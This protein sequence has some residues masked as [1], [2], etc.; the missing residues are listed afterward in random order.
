MHSPTLPFTVP[1]PA[2]L[3]FAFSLTALAVH[4]QT[5]SDRRK[6]RGLRYPLP[7]LLT[8]AV[9]AFPAGPGT[10]HG[11]Q[12]IKHTV[13]RFLTA[14]PDTRMPGEELIAEGDHVVGFLPFSR[15]RGAVDC[16]LR[17][18]TKMDT[19]SLA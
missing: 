8:L 10:R 11:L 13:T 17:C 5:V 19:S 3:P 1:L 9:L 7:V 2:D 18:E 14:F 4:L 15:T 6:R 16:E 12:G